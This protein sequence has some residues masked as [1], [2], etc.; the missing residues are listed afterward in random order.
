MTTS[1][2]RR[3]GPQRGERGRAR[4]HEPGPLLPGK[5]ASRVGSSSQHAAG[6]GWPHRAPSFGRR[7]PKSQG[8]PARVAA[9][10]GTEVQGHRFQLRAGAES[11]MAG[12]GGHKQFKHG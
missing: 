11:S 2:G 5:G 10:L 8:G 1:P 7:A 3:A 4:G 12:S 9:R 6:E